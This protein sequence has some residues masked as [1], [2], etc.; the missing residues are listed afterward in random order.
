MRRL[1]A[2][3]LLLLLAAG[4]GAAPATPAERVAKLRRMWGDEHADLGVWAAGKG[5]AAE[6][7]RH[8]LLA[9]RIDPECRTARLRLGHRRGED[10]AW[11]PLSDKTDW[12]TKAE[13]RKAAGAEWDRREDE[14][15][16]G[17]AAAYEA[18]GLELLALPAEA[19]TAR[20]LLRR[21]LALD[22]R[23]EK[24]ARVLGLAVVAEGFGTEAEAALLARIP[25]VSDAAA[26][27]WYGPLL[28]VPT[29][30]KACGAV[31]AETHS[32]PAAAARLA[33]SAAR[34]HLLTSARFGFSPY[35][36]GWVHLCVTR[37]LSEFGDLVTASGAFQEPLLSGVKALGS[38]RAF[39]PRH[40]IATWGL[41]P[42]DLEYNEQNLVHMTAEDTL[43]WSGAKHYRPWF[44]EAAGIDAALTLLGT[45]GPP[46]IALEES[47]GLTLKDALGDPARF[48]PRA[49][50]LLL[51]RRAPLLPGIARSS[52]Q[53]LAV[54]DIVVGYVAYRYLARRQP[55][56]LAK[57]L[58]SETEDPDRAFAEAFGQDPAACEEEIL[59]FLAGE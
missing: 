28:G 58:L 24:A 54:D 18:L 51:A 50:L 25:A 16:R 29:V 38:A 7:R 31:I 23:R 19:E 40:Y 49:L 21:A 55:E 39:Q 1:A 5:L 13:A 9:I 33:R 11:R 30:A 8:F 22:P 44:Y 17:E 52:I 10:G 56:A 15:F 42:G 41:F 46:C 47:S 4:A 36:T 3:T 26:A 57:Y 32:D 35:P 43:F 34:S 48:G 14:V 6:A 12:T 59:A 37:S 27:A 45:P 53:G 2:A 20:R